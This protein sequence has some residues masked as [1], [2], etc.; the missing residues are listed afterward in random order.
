MHFALS[1]M[2]HHHKISLLLKII[3]FTILFEMPQEDNELTVKHMYSFYLFKIN[4]N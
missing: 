1:R 2:P 3:T 4:L